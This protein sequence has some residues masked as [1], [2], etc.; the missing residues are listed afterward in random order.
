MED[1]L[2]II[3][4]IALATAGLL[5]VHLPFKKT[6]GIIQRP[7]RNQTRGVEARRLRQIYAARAVHG[8]NASILTIWQHWFASDALGIITVAPL[9]IELAHAVFEARLNSHDA[10]KLSCSGQV[11]HAGHRAH[12]LTQTDAAVLRIYLDTVIL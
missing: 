3:P 4:G 10:I 12:R 6:S 11:D 9:V 2:I 1:A 7:T 5:P 8:S